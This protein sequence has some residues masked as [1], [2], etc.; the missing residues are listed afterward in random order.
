MSFIGSMDGFV[1]SMC[2]IHPKN[3][4]DVANCMPDILYVVMGVI[5]EKKT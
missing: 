1:G 4:T 5:L 3:R 2:V